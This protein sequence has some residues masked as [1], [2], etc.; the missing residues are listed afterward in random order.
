MGA[1]CHLPSF[2]GRLSVRAPRLPKYT[3][4]EDCVW[5]DFVRFIRERGGKHPFVTLTSCSE[6]GAGNSHD[7]ID[8]AAGRRR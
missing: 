5:L 3:I 8:G 7:G 2:I 6:G 1:F 4:L